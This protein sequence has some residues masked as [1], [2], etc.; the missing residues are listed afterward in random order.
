MAQGGRLQNLVSAMAGQGVPPYADGTL[1]FLERDMEP[2][3]Q[4]TVHADQSSNSPTWQFT[5]QF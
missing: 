4:V 3:P 2:E 1:I 5:G